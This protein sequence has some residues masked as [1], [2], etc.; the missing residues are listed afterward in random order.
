ML[1][2]GTLN[3]QRV[4]YRDFNLNIVLAVDDSFKATFSDNRSAARLQIN[5][6]TLLFI[7]NN[8]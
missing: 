6:N 1:R 3:R 4:L 7:F 8:Q 2:S 5:I